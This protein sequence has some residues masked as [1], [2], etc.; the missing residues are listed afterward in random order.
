MSAPN[1]PAYPVM[2]KSE[3]WQNSNGTVLHHESVGGMTLR[4]RF[5]L[6]AMQGLLLKA[7]PNYLVGPCNAA[8]AERACLIADATLAKEK[9]TRI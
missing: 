8:I 5:V 1:D 7:A 2:D 3:V 6:A 9:E 4:Q